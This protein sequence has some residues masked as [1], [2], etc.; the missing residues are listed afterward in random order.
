MAMIIIR[1]K[2]ED[3]KPDW[4]GDI[5]NDGLSE[6]EFIA[7]SYTS[8]Q[9]YFIAIPERYLDLVNVPFTRIN[10][11]ANLPQTAKQNIGEYWRKKAQL[12]KRNPFS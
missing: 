4:M 7:H 12:P 9:N 3:M 5:P 11:N 6:S 8:G 1:I 10:P 2:K